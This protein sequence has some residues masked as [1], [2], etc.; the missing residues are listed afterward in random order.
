[1]QLDHDPRVP[2]KEWINHPSVQG[3]GIYNGELEWA[4]LA[5]LEVGAQLPGDPLSEIVPLILNES[6]R[7]KFC[8]IVDGLIICETG[9]NQIG[10]TKNMKN[11]FTTQSTRIEQMTETPP[12]ST[13]MSDE[14]RAFMDE[15]T[16][17]GKSREDCALEWQHK[18]GATQPPATTVP[19]F[20]APTTPLDQPEPPS[21]DLTA[22]PLPETEPPI[23][24][25]DLSPIV[26]DMSPIPAAAAEQVEPLDAAPP[27][28]EHASFIQACSAQGKSEEECEAEW[29]LRQELPSEFQPPAT[30]SRLLACSERNVQLQSR[31]AAKA[32]REVTLL[33]ENATLREQLSRASK[34]NIM[35][36]AEKEHTRLLKNENTQLRSHITKNNSLFTNTK[37]R[38][39]IQLKESIDEVRRLERKVDA[40]DAL[41]TE[42]QE[43]MDTLLIQSTRL[44]R[45]VSQ[46]TDKSTKSND[47]ARSAVK[48]RS[49]IQ[50]ENANLRDEAARMTRQL[51][52]LTEQ[53][54]VDAKKMYALEKRGLKMSES[55]S[56]GSKTVISL[57]KDLKVAGDRLNKAWNKLNELGEYVVKSDGTL[58]AGPP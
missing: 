47:R 34:V 8:K 43:K 14:E 27:Q 23:A 2:R 24:A 41:V 29:Q 9:V 7:S 40:K 13:E 6:I 10:E 31:L 35:Y 5:C 54:A 48:D 12:E 58:V 17:S 46:L 28:D 11:R 25:P 57:Q 3:Y 56:G 33:N 20:G 18:L 51:S 16:S 1:M 52:T 55:L 26:P 19:D 30:E 38:N 42:L 32:T 22:A 39:V 44:R 15:C 37:D 21:F 50:I 45:D 36:D 49:D 53:R 4:G